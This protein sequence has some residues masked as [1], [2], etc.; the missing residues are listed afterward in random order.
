MQCLCFSKY[1][2]YVFKI[3]QVIEKVRQESKQEKGKKCLNI[4]AHPKL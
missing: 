1:L 4:K 2:T 3:S